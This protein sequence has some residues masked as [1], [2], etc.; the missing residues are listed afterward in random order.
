MNARPDR[1]SKWWRDRAAQAR[2]RAAAFRDP[3][4][5]QEMENIARHYEAMAE[6][7]EQQ[8]TDSGSS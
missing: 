6:R 3:D 4:A 2:A 8:E 5:R 7:A 1:D